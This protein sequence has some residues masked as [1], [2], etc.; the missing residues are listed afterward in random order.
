MDGRRPVVFVGVS[1]IVLGSGTGLPDAQRGPAGF[2]WQTPAGCWLVDGGSG[3]LQRC[4][5]VGVDPTALSGGVY[6][7]R[8]P[9]HSGDLVPLLFAQRI[10][11]RPVQYPIWAGQGFTTFYEGLEAVYG[12]WLHG[13]GG[14]PLV[15]ELS[16]QRVQRTPIADWVLE[17]APANHSA[18][19]LH[20]AFEHN[21]HRVVFSGDTGPSAALTELAR[22]ANLLVCGC[23]APD[24]AILAGHL[25][26][27]AVAEIAAEARPDEIWL[28]HFYP[29]TSP[30]SAVR[31]VAKT[32]V[33]TRRA[34]DG[35]HW[36]SPCI[37]G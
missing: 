23:A 14:P 11:R 37:P 21:G 27:S 22:G 25:H 1:F 29:N 20:L 35:D 15:H 30:A 19:A 5:R 6:S 8:H 7:H 13:A 3:T 24:D 12:H 34:S 2:L 4:A 17:T 9:D 36:R 26:P 28:T 16:L 18:G 33:P 31:T 32:G 10:A